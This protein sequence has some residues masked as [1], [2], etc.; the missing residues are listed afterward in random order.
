MSYY[1]TTT[2]FDISY[3]VNRVAQYLQAPTLGT[4]KAIK[5]ILVYLSGTADKGLRVARVGTTDWQIYS[6]SDHAGD[7]Q[8]NQTRKCH[9]NVGHV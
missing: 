3:E 8:A 1:A 9:G 2:R 7:R 6:D 5:R 4:V